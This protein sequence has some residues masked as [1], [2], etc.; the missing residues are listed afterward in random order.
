[1]RY[2]VSACSS[3]GLLSRIEQ[4][5]FPR[6]TEGSMG[7]NN[8]L[9]HKAEKFG[10]AT[11]SAANRGCIWRGFDAHAEPTAVL[12]MTA[13]V[14]LRTCEMRRGRSIVIHVPILVS[15]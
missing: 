7:R 3:N 13:M 15:P 6:A 11:T 9:W 14:G 10:S 1:M 8:R 2:V 12:L 5:A 4:H